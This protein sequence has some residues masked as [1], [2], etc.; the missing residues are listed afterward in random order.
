MAGGSRQVGDKV[1]QVPAAAAVDTPHTHRQMGWNTE[2]QIHTLRV[3]GTTEDQ[4]V[5]TAADCG[6]G[7]TDTSLVAQQQQEDSL[8]PAPGSCQREAAAAAAAGHKVWDMVPP[9]VA[10]VAG[11]MGWDRDCLCHCWLLLK[12][13]GINQCK[14]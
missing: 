10:V 14:Q 4:L 2:Q 12:I 5:G 8:L 11:C 3:E 9:A 13:S 1:L 7:K 6:L